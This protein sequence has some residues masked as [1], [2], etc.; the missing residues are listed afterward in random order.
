MASAA[1]PYLRL[2]AHVVTWAAV[3]IVLGSLVGFAAVILPPVGTFGI[4]AVAAIV[5]LWVMPELPTVADS[6]IRRLFFAV[7][8]VN[9]CVPVYYA[10]TIPGSGIPWVSLRRLVTFALVTVFGYNYAASSDFRKFIKGILSANYVT[11]SCVIGFY[12]LAC[13][14]ILTSI[15]PAA[16]LDQAMTV[17]LEWYVAFF[18]T[19]YVIRNEQQ[20]QTLIFLLCCCAIFI[21][22]AG[23][24]EY[25]LWRNLFLAILPEAVKEALAAGSPTFQAMITVLPLRD[26]HWRA[27]SLF[28]NALS[29][30]Q[31]EAL[32]AP[33]AFVWMAHGRSGR[34]RAFGAVVT[35]SVMFGIFASGSRG[36]YVA[37]IVATA[38]F[39]AI[40][41]IRKW[42][43]ERRSLGPALVGFM[44]AAGFAV[45]IPLILFYPRVHNAVLGGGAEAAS[46]EGRRVQWAMGITHIESNPITGHGFGQGATIIG[47]FNPGAS[48]PTV[49]S[50]ILSML[51]EVGVPGM[52]LFV[53][54]VLS[55]SWSGLR[56]YLTDPSFNGALGGGLS[57]AM[58]A[59]LV[60]LTVLSQRDN[61]G[62]M[63]I[64][65]ACVILQESF[66]KKARSESS[67]I[68][69]TV[70]TV[71]RSPTA[72]VRSGASL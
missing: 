5:L 44:G 30:A 41:L 2:G 32:V 22:A 42:K 45:L 28:V 69:S 8:L 48:F 26:G 62:Y 40:W 11:S 31:F 23:V 35:V 46:D 25:F 49:D 17:F 55:A 63:F 12:V 4:V 6:T 1:P 52:V 51:V 24:V 67:G 18:A 3:A 72:A 21:S 68:R 60:Y 33:I 10:F 50:G 66:A 53:G 27:S 29:F 64:L 54:M 16:T 38:Y 43:F 15:S 37:L 58:L 36:G 7:V 65:I 9:L 39:V 57:A 19:L 71:G 20:L 61:H 56:R 34:L 59:F 14:S 70:S 13:L 47:Y